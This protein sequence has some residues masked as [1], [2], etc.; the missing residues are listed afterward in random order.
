[1]KNEKI[2][3]CCYLWHLARCLLALE[4]RNKN[5]WIYMKKVYAARASCVRKLTKRNHVKHC[6]TVY[7]ASTIVS[8][9]NNHR[10]EFNWKQKFYDYIRYEQKTCSGRICEWI[11]SEIFAFHLSPH[12]LLF[13]SFHWW[14]ELPF[15]SCEVQCR[16]NH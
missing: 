6:N 11:H 1:M 3:C 7:N 10:C 14:N 8:S 16:S 13:L 4:T 9:N 12:L 2:S 5:R 15:I